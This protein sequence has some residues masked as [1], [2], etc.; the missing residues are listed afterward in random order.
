MGEIS[1]YGMKYMHHQPI[2]W[3][4]GYTGQHNDSGRAYLVVKESKIS[5]KIIFNYR[6]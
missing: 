5:G 4:S 2:Y 6:A 3:L 1:I